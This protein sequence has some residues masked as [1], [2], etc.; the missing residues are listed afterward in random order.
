MDLPKWYFRKS[1]IEHMQSHFSLLLIKCSL[2]LTEDT[3]YRRKMGYKREFCCYP[4]KILVKET[5]DK[6]YFLL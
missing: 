4:N 5:F 2:S 3:E 6:V 1:R